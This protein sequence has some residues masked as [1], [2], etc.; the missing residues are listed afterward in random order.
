MLSGELAKFLGGLALPAELG[1]G[2]AE[3]LELGD[4]GGHRCW[5][6]IQG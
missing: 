3:D 6:S 2:Q 4:E 5:L 1:D